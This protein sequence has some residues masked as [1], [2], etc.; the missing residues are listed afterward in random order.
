LLLCGGTPFLYKHRTLVKP[1]WALNWLL[2]W[3]SS[4]AVLNI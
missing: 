4:Q 2:N 3:L 1:T